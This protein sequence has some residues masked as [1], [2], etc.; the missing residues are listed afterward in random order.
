MKGNRLSVGSMKNN[1]NIIGYEKIL[2]RIS[3]LL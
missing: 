2:D 3:M 1:K